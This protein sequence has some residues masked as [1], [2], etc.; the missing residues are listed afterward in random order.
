VSPL[1]A[2]PTETT[3]RPL[4]L[5]ETLEHQV[6]ACRDAHRRGRAELATLLRGHALASG[7]DE[8]I[9]ATDLTLETARLLVAREHEFRDWTDAMAHGDELVDRAFEAAVD[10]V[11]D[12]DLEALERLLSERPD[13]ARARSAF[14]HRSTLLHY[15]AA[16]GVEQT[17]QRS[18]ADAPA[19]TRALLD[20]G[21][22]PNAQS[23][24]YGGTCT[25]TLELLVSSC[26]P[27]GAGV[28]ADLVE[29][30]CRGRAMVEGLED[31]G[32]PLWTAITWGYTRAAERLVACGAR[33]DN[34][35]AAAVVGTVDE[36][37]AYF[38]PDGRLRP[39]EQL[40][41]ARHFSH[42]RPL[43]LSHVLEYALIWA[44]GHGRREVVEFLLS[45]GPDLD[46]REPVYRN[47]ALD[48][49]KYSHPAAGL[50]HGSPDIVA[51]LAA[52]RR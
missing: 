12:G 24:A 41:G 28:Q 1:I 5:R 6:E 49:A 4:S 2:L 27:A 7:T 16:N 37:R 3:G 17:K 11:V 50:P 23:G 31:D 19:I 22:D 15:T 25:T 20:A 14:G 10:A 36:V 18:P 30:L 35:I 42:G 48:A 44:A 47:T 46:V 51:L 34:V 32:A 39:I 33:V 26:H 29:V 9:F 45:K 13:L 52:P 21:A 40:R 8:E 43:D 38:G